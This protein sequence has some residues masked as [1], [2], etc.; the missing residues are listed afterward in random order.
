MIQLREYQISAI[1]AIKQTF[2][3][4]NR[5]YVELPT[6]AGKTITFLSYASKNHD[7]VLIIVPTKELLSQVYDSCLLF[8]HSSEISRKGAHYSETPKRVHICIINST[9]GK[10]LDLL[11]KNDFS[12]VIVDEAHHS[13][14][15]S[16]VRLIESFDKNIKVLGVTATPTRLDGKL[17]DGI[18]HV[19]SYKT[20]IFELIQKKY[21]CDVEGFAV[22]TDIDLSEVDDHNG[23]FGIRHLYRILATEKRNKLIIDLIKNQMQNRKV[24]VFCINIKHCEELV[25]LMKKED[26]SCSYIHGKMPNKIRQMHKSIA[27]YAHS[28]KLKYKLK[29]LK[30]IF[31]YFPNNTCNPHVF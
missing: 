12:L 8:Y 31:R 7:R 14:S 16:Y 21:L 22:K 6:G 10:Y 15:D 20:S 1:E 19:R 11:L 24:L 17:L 9:R 26:V 2:M 13:Q 5:Q 27:G 25:D 30:L 23:D 18:L 4:A 3:E 29:F 28:K